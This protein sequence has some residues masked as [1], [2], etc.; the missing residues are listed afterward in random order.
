MGTVPRAGGGVSGA[1]GLALSSNYAK[2]HAATC[3][4][5][6]CVSRVLVQAHAQAEANALRMDLEQRLAAATK[7][8][9]AAREENSALREQLGKLLEEAAAGRAATDGAPFTFAS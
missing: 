8:A 3:N 5:C 7:E 2:A 4:V 9:R 1:H 6:R